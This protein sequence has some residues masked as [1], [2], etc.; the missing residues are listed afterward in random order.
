MV[1]GRQGFDAARRRGARWLGSWPVGQEDRSGDDHQRKQDGEDGRDPL[2]PGRGVRR[3]RATLQEASHH[4]V[5]DCASGELTED[6]VRR[7]PVA[8]VVRV[9]RRQAVFHERGEGDAPQDHEGPGRCAPVQGPEGQGEE[10]EGQVGQPFHRQGPRHVVPAA[11]WVGAPFLD[12]QEV[13]GEVDR[14]EPGA[15]RL[16]ARDLRLNDDG[17]P[18]NHQHDQVDGVDPGEAQPPEAQGG[19]AS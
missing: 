3:S 8:A 1:V 18:G 13:L 6:A 12:K 15:A 9:R 4:E 11:A 10:R 2:H 16:L 19:P 7:P 14:V 17:Q 5:R